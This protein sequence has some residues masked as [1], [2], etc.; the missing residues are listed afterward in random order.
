MAAQTTLPTSACQ[1]TNAPAL[2][3]RQESPQNE[4]RGAD[5]HNGVITIPPAR[6]IWN[7]LVSGLAYI[8]NG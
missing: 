7:R 8:P 4:R 5:H 6:A 1:E 2:S 3:D